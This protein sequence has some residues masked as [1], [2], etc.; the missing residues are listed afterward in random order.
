MGLQ[1]PLTATAEPKQQRDIITVLRR[2]HT[3]PPKEHSVAVMTTACTSL[4]AH[5]GFVYFSLA[6][7]TLHDEVAAPRTSLGVDVIRLG[8]AVAAVG[9]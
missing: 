8:A 4:L 1:A 2:Q 9:Q 5:P 7:H 3:W 6:T